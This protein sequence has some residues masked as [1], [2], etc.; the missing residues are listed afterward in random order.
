MCHSFIILLKFRA[1]KKTQSLPGSVQDYVLF[2]LSCPNSKKG[3]KWPKLAIK[4]SET[5]LTIL[6]P[7]CIK[8]ELL[9]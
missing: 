2:F 6:G 1:Y 9:N 7:H 4:N 8:N 5:V 3:K